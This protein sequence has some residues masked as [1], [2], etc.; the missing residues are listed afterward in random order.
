MSR[1]IFAVLLAALA[2]A[3][4]AQQL[5][6]DDAID[7]PKCNPEDAA[8][9]NNHGNCLESGECECLMSN[10]GGVYSGISCQ[11]GGTEE[12]C[13]ADS[14]SGCHWCTTVDPPVCVISTQVCHALSLPMTE[15]GEGDESYRDTSTTFPGGYSNSESKSNS[16]YFFIGSVVAIA[17]F[18]WYF[19]LRGAGAPIEDDMPPLRQRTS[20]SA[21]EMQGDGL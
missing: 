5:P 2:L 13:T 7:F 19:K 20:A 1:M 12:E 15:T 16:M 6:E 8:A 18:A 10:E 17:A 3:V 11:C 9:C 4:N 14:K 21:F